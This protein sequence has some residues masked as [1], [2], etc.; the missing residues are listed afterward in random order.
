MRIHSRPD[1]ALIMNFF[2]RSIYQK[3]ATKNLALET[4]M[5]QKLEF[6]DIIDNSFSTREINIKM[7][8]Q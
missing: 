6:M 7:G 3:F 5:L 1:I 2:T 8:F 4:F